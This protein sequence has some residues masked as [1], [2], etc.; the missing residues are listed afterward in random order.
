MKLVE[1]VPNFSEGQR[2]DVVA[3]I[4]AAMARVP[5]ARVLD[6]HTD[7]DHN[8]SV[9]TC[10]GEPR[11]ALEAAYQ[12]IAEAARRIDLTQ[13]QGQ[14]PFIGAA[15]VVPFVPLE[16]MTMDEAVALARELG[17]RVGNELGLPVY[18]YAE[19]ALRPE[20]RALENIRR[21]GYAALRAGIGRDPR[22]EPDFGPARV[23]PAGAVVIGARD[24]LIAFNVYLTTDDVTIAKRIARAVRHSSG[25]LRYVKALGMKVRG[26]AQVSMNLT[27]FRRTPIARVVELIRREAQRYGV[28]IHHSELV[29]LAPMDAFLDAARW[30]LQLDDFRGAEQVLEPRLTEAFWRPARDMWHWTQDPSHPYPSGVAVAAHSGAMALALLAKLLARR[31]M[32]EAARQAREWSARCQAEA[33]ADAWAVWAALQASEAGPG[34]PSLPTLAASGWAVLETCR[35]ARAWVESL[36]P[37]QTPGPQAD[38]RTAQQLLAW[39]EHALADLVA[40]ENP[41]SS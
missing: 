12:G 4:A 14:H 25:G 28:T 2:L 8:R 40:T 38:W 20:R 32:R 15:D 33:E 34:S 39:A 10:A 23:G 11:A 3:A 9:I 21:G 41:T 36:T 5:A 27:N 19:A 7:A 1:C 37:P 31:G 30:Y 6:I 16:D 24:F 29:G 35:K 13:H 22:W 26:L 18:L 17:Q